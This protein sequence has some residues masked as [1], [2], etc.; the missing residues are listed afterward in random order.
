MKP[1]L[2]KVF[3]PATFS[4]SSPLAQVTAAEQPELT[5]HLIIRGQYE[6][7]SLCV[8]GTVI[9]PHEL[10]AA[11][12]TPNPEGLLYVDGS[13]SCCLFPNRPVPELLKI[14]SVISA[15]RSMQPILQFEQLPEPTQ[16]C[17]AL[18]LLRPV[19]RR[20]CSDCCR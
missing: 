2:S 4:D 20:C 16:V 13:N 11:S 15:P 12:E 18:L 19:L 1:S 5:L 17:T 8:Y 10:S 3:G 7:L 14:D 9:L 6:S